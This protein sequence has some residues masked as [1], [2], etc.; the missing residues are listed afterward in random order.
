MSLP[1]TTVEQSFTNVI[2]NVPLTVNI[3]TSGVKSE[4]R[5]RYGA[6]ELLAVQDVDYTIL[7][8]GNLLSFTF[9]PLQP[10]LDK[11]AISG[12]NVVSILRWLIPTTDF[13]YDDAFVR[14]ELVSEFDR[15]WM[16]AQQMAWR[17]DNL[18]A[19][20]SSP[21]LGPIAP[22]QPSANTFP[23]YTSATA[24]ALAEITAFGRSLVDDP[25]ATTARVTLGVVIGTNVQ[26]QNAN[27]SA[28]AALTTA[29][30][31][32]S[33]WTGAGTAV[34]ITTTAFGR[35]LLNE[36][37]YAGLKTNMA[38]TKSDVGLGNVDNTSDATKNSAVATLTNKTIN[39]SN[40]NISNI[41]D[42]EIA[43]GAAIAATKIGNGSVTTAEFQFLSNVTSDIQAQLNARLTDAPN[44][45]NI[46][47][48][49]AAAWV[50]IPGGGGGITDAP[51]DGTTYGRLNAAWV[52]VQPSDADLTALAALAATA[53]MLSRTGAGAFA[54][55]TLTAGANISISN[56]TGAGG[57][58]T[59]AVTGIGTTIQAFDATLA[60]IAAITGA[61]NDMFY[62]SGA[63]AVTKIANTTA[64]G[65]GL[66]TSADLAAIVGASSAAL[67]NTGT[68]GNTVPLLDGNNTWSGTNVFS[69]AIR[70]G[71]V[72]LT[73]GATPALDASLGN[74][75][76]LTTTTNPTIAVP[77]N[78][79]VGQRITIAITASGAN[80]TASLNTGAGGFTFGSDIT[81]LTA[82][83]SGKTDYI[84][85]QYNGSKWDV[86]GYVKG[87]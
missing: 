74:H 40:N 61:A 24:A 1:G 48:R 33:Y 19:D 8:A 59:I 56:P 84:A 16:E 29:N 45:A 46:Y 2:V 71:V 20:A 27:L 69:K 86:T 26:A 62:F 52:A 34:T 76:T 30:N 58:P 11:I 42:S 78:A 4:V 85:A 66:L 38:F 10:L 68:S 55:R 54:V 75:F 31:L 82:T 70:I 79:A 36:A 43:A 21:G 44:N 25:D 63:D 14:E 41:T 15:V 50:I 28:I 23:Y 87:Y 12:P 18:E 5:V 64:Y 53:G 32:M 60:G 80:R 57:D 81:A 49:Q 73:D 22:L 17:L 13:D 39:A 65:R 35:S 7:F 67:K 6:L 47:G 3:Q 83:V 9:T 77:S 37:S 51:S 72:A